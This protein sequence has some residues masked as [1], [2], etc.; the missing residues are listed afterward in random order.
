MMEDM[1]T[2]SC[3]PGAE[4]EFFFPF[5]PFLFRWHL[6]S[7]D[8]GLRTIGSRAIESMMEPEK[9]ET[10]HKIRVSKHLRPL[11]GRWFVRKRVRFLT[12]NLTRN[13]RGFS[14]ILRGNC[15]R[16]LRAAGERRKLTAA[17]PDFTAQETEKT[18]IERNRINQG[19]PGNWHLEFVRF[20]VR[21]GVRNL[22]RN[23]R[24]NSQKISEKSTP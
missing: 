4:W 7:I 22:T 23:L 6:L 10:S 21:N 8:S 11:S 12:R 1:L 19:F 2:C 16:F 20:P 15:G 13:L 18:K 24:E 14:E 9:A 3:L 5:C 17:F